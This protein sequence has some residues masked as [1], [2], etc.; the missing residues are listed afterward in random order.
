MHIIITMLMAK[1]VIRN[2]NIMTS[3]K[4]ITAK[5]YEYIDISITSKLF[6]TTVIV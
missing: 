1:I 5:K 3:D 4:W 2:D 6:I